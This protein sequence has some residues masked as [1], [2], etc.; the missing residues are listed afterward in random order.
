VQVI[1]EMNNYCLE[2]LQ[3]ADIEHRLID[4]YKCSKEIKATTMTGKPLD[5][6]QPHKG[7]V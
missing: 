2:C 5:L 3:K 1:K 6:T 7:F 4:C